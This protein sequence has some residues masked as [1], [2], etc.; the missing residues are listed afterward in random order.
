[1]IRMLIIGYVFAVR[2]ERGSLVLRAVLK[3]RYQIIRRSRVRATNAS[4]AA[5]SFGVCLSVW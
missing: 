3:T 1:M 5:A 2:S 4:A